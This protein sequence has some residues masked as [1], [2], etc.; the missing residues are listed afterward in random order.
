MA[1]MSKVLGDEDLLRGILLRV[2]F[3]TTLV[4]ASLVCR[5]WYLCASDPAFL[6]HFRD[7]HLPPLR[8]FYLELWSDNSHFR[9][10]FVPV[11]LPSELGAVVRRGGFDLD[12]YEAYAA[13]VLRRP[14]C[15]L[16]SYRGYA[17]A[18]VKVQ[19]WSGHVFAEI[20][21]S[22]RRVEAV[23]SPLFPGRD[24]AILPPFP[25]PR[26]RMGYIIQSGIF[27]TPYQKMRKDCQQ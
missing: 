14:A 12:T 1:A 2:G 16:D 4:S 23:C 10:R 27:G 18:S 22:H 5:R 25:S 3:P 17:A 8:G 11:P 26:V 24:L 15:Y 21:N 7:L 6:R 13:V 19:C 9:S 20:S